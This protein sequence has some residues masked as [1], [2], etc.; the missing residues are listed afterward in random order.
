MTRCDKC[1]KKVGIQ[2]FDCKWCSA[3]TCLG[4]HKPEKHQ[5]VGMKEMKTAKQELLAD[6]LMSAKMNAQHN[7]EAF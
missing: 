7:Y 1:N 2:G 5:C 6:G 4:C 3:H